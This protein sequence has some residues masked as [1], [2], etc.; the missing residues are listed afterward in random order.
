MP[1]EV[2]KVLEF[3]T[4]HAN[5]GY[6][7]FTWMLVDSDIAYLPESAVYRLLKVNNKLGLFYNHMSSAG[8]EYTNKHKRVHHHWH[9]DIAYIK[10][11][12]VFYFLIMALDGYSRFILDWDLMTDMTGISVEDFIHRVREKY[13]NE[14][15]TIISDNGSQFISR[16]FKVLI[17]NLDIQHIRTRRNH[18]ETNGK[19]EILNGSV[20]REAIR[21]NA[22]QS[23]QEAW[24]IL[25]DYVYTYCYQ[26]LHAGIQYLRPADVFFGRDQI[27]LKER[28]IKIKL[29]KQNRIMI[30]KTKAMSSM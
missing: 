1:E 26:R 11:R 10:I 21:P 9:V 15:P 18:P 5:V 12:G 7:K 22:P 29:A 6:R 28:S 8:K 13:K 2:N 23:F 4:Q 19:I 14:K 17:S 27:I 3:R 20:K 16:D 25:N 24:D 30:N